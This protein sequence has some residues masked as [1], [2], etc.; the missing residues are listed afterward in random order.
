MSRN[1]QTGIRRTK[2]SWGAELSKPKRL[3]ILTRKTRGGGAENFS[4]ALALALRER[5]EVE[6]CATRAQEEELSELRGAGIQVNSLARGGERTISSI[7]DPRPWVW[8][9][10]RLRAQNIEILNAHTFGSNVWGTI[11]GRIAGVPVIVAT[12]HTWSFEGAPIR[13]FLDRELIGRFA[14]AFVAISAQ[15][16]ERMITVEG[17]PAQKIRLIE[18]GLPEGFRAAPGDGEAVRREFGIPAEAFV[19]GVVAVLRA[20]KALDVLIRAF[21]K[22]RLPQSDARL[23]IVGD[24]PERA[25]LEEVARQSGVSDSVIFAGRR[26][27]VQG[28]YDAF[29]VMALSSRYEG[30]PLAVLEAMACECPVISSRVGGLPEIL[31]NGEAGVLV[32]PGDDEELAEAIG[33]LAS[34]P[35]LRIRIS[36]AARKRLERN[37]SFERV[38]QQWATLFEALHERGT[39]GRARSRVRHMLGR[40]C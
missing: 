39:N 30:T 26:P 23:M 7:L 22:A 21:S 18:N 2:Q 5:F 4:S 20:Q 38:T 3:M 24:G 31:A 35:A 9:V 6:V 12:E 10:R 34:D 37:Y 27:D 33:R 13:K 32:A 8:L 14:S 36:K 29:D 28:C 40:R 15:D 19:V 11:L 16:A 17:V 25:T 1:W